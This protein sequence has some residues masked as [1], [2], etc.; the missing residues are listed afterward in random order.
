M[1]KANKVASDPDFRAEYDFATI[2]GGVRGKYAERYWAGVDV[3]L[4]QAGSA[5][6]LP[7]ADSAKEPSGQLD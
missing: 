5:A 6:A 7:A 1:K 3:V 4:L 2:K